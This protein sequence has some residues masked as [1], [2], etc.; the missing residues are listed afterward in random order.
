MAA[1]TFVLYFTMKFYLK[2]GPNMFILLSQI[3]NYL[4]IFLS[5][6]HVVICHVF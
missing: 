2:V 6:L 5:F 1:M 3:S 4:R